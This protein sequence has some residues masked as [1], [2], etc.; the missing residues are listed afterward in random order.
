MVFRA[1]AVLFPVPRC[2]FGHSRGAVCTHLCTRYAIPGIS[3]V[4][5]GMSGV[6]TV[7]FARTDAHLP[8]PEPI[9]DNGPQPGQFYGQPAFARGPTAPRQFAQQQQPRTGNGLM[10]NPFR[11][12]GL[13]RPSPRFLTTGSWCFCLGGG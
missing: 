12:Q 4:R 9:A 1:R 5:D 8:L 10:N 6:L 2:Y 7:P 11:A 3:C 13:P